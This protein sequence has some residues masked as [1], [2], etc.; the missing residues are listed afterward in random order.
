MDVKCV[1]PFI[2]SVF[3]F[4]TT[5]VSAE[6]KRGEIGILDSSEH[7]KDANVITALIGLSG[8]TRGAVA[9]VF[10]FETAAAV[11]GAMLGMEVTDDDTVKDGVAETVNMIAGNA[12][13][14]LNK[15]TGEPMSLG[16]PTVIRGGNYSIEYPSDSIWLQVPFESSLGSV[17]LRVTFEENTK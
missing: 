16:L 5:M 2:E 9:L 14:K 7:P 11:V 13:A 15:L 10:P 6:V 1:N 3:D 4:F 8:L 12:K 17:V